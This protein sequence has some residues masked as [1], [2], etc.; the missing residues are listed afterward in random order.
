MSTPLAAIILV[1]LCAAIGIVARVLV[2]SVGRLGRAIRLNEF[3]LGFIVLG[4][5]TSF[6]EMTVGINAIAE[7]VPT[8]SFGNLV[9]GTIILLSLVAGLNAILN[10]EIRIKGNLRLGTL[11]VSSLVI[12]LPSLLVLDASL[13][14]IDAALCFSAYVIHI[15]WLI[16]QNR[17]RDRIKDEAPPKKLSS[18]GAAFLF[19]GSLGLLILF[20]RALVNVATVLASNLSLPPLVVGL[21]I[22]GVGTNLPE[23]TLTLTAR[24]NNRSIV[25][26]DVLGSATANTLLIGLLG[27]ISP[28]V[29]SARLPLYT[30]FATLLLVVATLFLSSRSERKLSRQ[31][32]F[33]LVALYALFL[34]LESFSAARLHG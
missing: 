9:S 11:A 27:L 29:F 23:L 19:L 8:L 5:A 34:A 31:E 10:R 26:G 17:G 32:G 22:L 14:R 33:V 15:I 16:R 25:F 18:L 28:M 20:A 3:I 1:I 2:R 21:L 4:I 24:R 7:G 13:S 6:P 30:S 12:L